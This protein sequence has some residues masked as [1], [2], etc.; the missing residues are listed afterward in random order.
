MSLSGPEPGLP[1]GR[2][3]WTPRSSSQGLGVG[4]DAAGQQLGLRS[5][6]PQ[7][8]AWPLAP[9]DTALGP[10]PPSFELET[11]RVWPMKHFIPANFY[12]VSERSLVGR[13]C[14]IFLY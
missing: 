12:L 2:G 5:G 8:P 1:A 13:S 6:W 3:P 11:C 9:R 4:G 10:A 14:L 7:A